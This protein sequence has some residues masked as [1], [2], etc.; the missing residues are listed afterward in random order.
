MFKINT[1]SLVKN[2]AKGGTPDTEK[3]ITVSRKIL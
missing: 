3:R 1:S 2:P